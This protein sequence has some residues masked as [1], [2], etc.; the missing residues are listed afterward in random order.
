MPAASLLER[1]LTYCSSSGTVPSRAESAGNVADALARAFS[2][3]R[4][5]GEV[6]PGARPLIFVGGSAYVV[7]EALPVLSDNSEKS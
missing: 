5:I 2:R 4:E 6:N 1:Y 3:A 7:S